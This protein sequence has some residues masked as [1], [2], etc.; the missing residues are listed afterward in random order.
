[1][2]EALG[3]VSSQWKVI[4]DVSGARCY[5]YYYHSLLHSKTVP[6][7]TKVLIEGAKHFV[8]SNQISRKRKLSARELDAFRAIHS[9]TND[10]VVGCV[11]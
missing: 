10:L 6:Y 2:C 8:F 11:A 1:M 5:Y 7:V 9:P 3:T 4:H